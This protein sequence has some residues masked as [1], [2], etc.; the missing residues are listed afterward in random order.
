MQSTVE[1]DWTGSGTNQ[2]T[3]DTVKVIEV[4]QWGQHMLTIVGKW[5]QGDY[6]IH[7]A[8]CYI[9]VARST[10]PTAEAVYLKYTQCGFE[11]HV[12]HCIR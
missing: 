9:D 6:R 4:D 3:C 10:S 1:S 2:I 5:E 7:D 12:E 11:S 8:L